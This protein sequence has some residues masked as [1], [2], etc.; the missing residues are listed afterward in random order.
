[1]KY[2]LIIYNSGMRAEVFETDKLR[3]IGPNALMMVDV[4]AEG[5]T[6]E[7]TACGTILAVTNAKQKSLYGM[8][9][10]EYS[11]LNRDKDRHEYKITFFGRLEP[12]VFQTDAVIHLIPNAVITFICS[13]TSKQYFLTSPFVIEQRGDNT[14][15]P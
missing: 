1:M 3:P 2:E 5:N 10:A 9:L 4:D 8:P 14:I 6:V 13:D 15:W 12:M 7:R 11:V